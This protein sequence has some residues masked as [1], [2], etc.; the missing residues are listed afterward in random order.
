MTTNR[1]I[2]EVYV[3]DDRYAVPTLQF[4][5]ASDEADALRNLERLVQESPHHLGGELCLEGHLLARIGA[6]A[7]RP[8]PSL[9]VVS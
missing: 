6:L 5:A 2:F 3:D 8:R 9:A 1:P 4:I 7:G